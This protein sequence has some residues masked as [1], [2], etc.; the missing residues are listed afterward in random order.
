MWRLN[1]NK[2][3]TNNFLLILIIITHDQSLS[4]FD[5][6]VMHFDLNVCTVKIY[7]LKQSVIIVQEH[8]KCALF[9]SLYSILQP[10]SNMCTWGRSRFCHLTEY[11]LRGIFL[12]SSFWVLLCEASIEYPSSHT[13]KNIKWY[14]HVS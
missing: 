11:T 9:Y 1:L 3:F 4:V 5:S 7:L 10:Y 12:I 2:T 13:I 6:Y 8:E 14:W